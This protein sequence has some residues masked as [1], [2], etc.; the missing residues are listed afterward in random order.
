MDYPA[1]D[2][3]RLELTEPELNRR[4]NALDAHRSQLQSSHHAPILSPN[5]FEHL[6]IELRALRGG[7]MSTTSRDFFERMYRASPDPWSFTS[8]RYERS[9]TPGRSNSFL[10]SLSQRLR[11]WLLDR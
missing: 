10:R 8:S 7:V 5:L 11:T 9:A 1:L 6:G 4:L 3:R 2:V